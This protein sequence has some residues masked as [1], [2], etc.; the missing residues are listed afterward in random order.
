[1]SEMAKN[2]LHRI[3]EATDSL[4]AAAQDGDDYLTDIRVSELQELQRLAQ[5]H[6]IPVPGIEDTIAAHTGELPIVQPQRRN[7]AVSEHD[8]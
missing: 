2:L 1:M 5:D 7:T 3:T 4:Q 6:G 8:A